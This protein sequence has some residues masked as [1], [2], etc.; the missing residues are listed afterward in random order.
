MNQDT[1]DKKTSRLQAIHCWPLHEVKLSEVR[2]PNNSGK[3][4]KDGN[5]LYVINIKSKSLSYVYQTDRYD[6]FLKITEAYNKGRNEILA[7]ERIL[8]SK[9]IGQTLTLLKPTKKNVNYVNH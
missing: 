4:D 8:N 5:K 1:G 6:H 9:S 2:V 7:K 3:T